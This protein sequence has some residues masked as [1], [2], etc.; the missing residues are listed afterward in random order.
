MLFLL[1]LALHFYPLMISPR[2]MEYITHLDV[3]IS[4]VEAENLMYRMIFH[5]FK[6]DKYIFFI[7]NWRIDDGAS[8][9]HHLN[10]SHSFIMLQLH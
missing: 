4:Y 8:F 7:F 5:T 1:Y 9:F 2:F 10:S 6:Q 3:S